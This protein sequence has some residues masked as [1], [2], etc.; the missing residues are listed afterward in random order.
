MPLK[1]V[2]NNLVARVKAGVVAKLG[3]TAYND[4]LDQV[5]PQVL[6]QVVSNS[7]SSTPPTNEY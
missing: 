1:S 6:A 2:D 5:I 4:L 7:Q 3:T